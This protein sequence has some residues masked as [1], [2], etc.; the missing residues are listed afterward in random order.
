MSTIT[1]SPTAYAQA[2]AYATT[3]GVSLSEAVEQAI[4]SLHQRMETACRNNP[5]PSGDPWWDDPE[6]VAKV[7][8]AL[9]QE[10]Q[11]LGKIY[12]RE[13]IRQLLGL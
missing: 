11:G 12:T 1:I 5:S 6:N 7:E 3:C 8:R 2:E 13:E 4:D 10:R 9:E